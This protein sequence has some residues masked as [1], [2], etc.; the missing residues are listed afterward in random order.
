MN[1]CRRIFL[2]GGWGI[3]AGY[4]TTTGQQL[5]IENLTLTPFTGDVSTRC[6][7][8]AGNG[9]WTITLKETG[10]LAVTV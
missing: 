6:Y 4:S 10:V 2:P 7:L 1:S 5:W 3:F 8:L 9:V